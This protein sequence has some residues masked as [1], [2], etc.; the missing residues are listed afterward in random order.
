MGPFFMAM[1][2]RN[3]KILNWFGIQGIVLYPF[4]IFAS[5]FPH[6]DIENHERIHWDQIRRD[7]ILIFYGR[8]L[9]EYFSGR[10]QGFSHDKAY[11]EISYEK[12][13]YLHQK[14][15]QYAVK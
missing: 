7:G 10:R 1:K 3:V 12:E 8:Y 2:I 14:D 6:P 4:I 9:K 11:R 5:K 15:Y 13:A